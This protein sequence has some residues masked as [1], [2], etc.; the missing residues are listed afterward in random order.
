VGNVTLS[1][2]VHQL[3][4]AQRKLAREINP[5]VYTPDEISAELRQGHHFVQHLMKQPRLVVA[6]SEHELRSILTS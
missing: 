2:I 5:I 6:G 1:Q 4:P 3:Q